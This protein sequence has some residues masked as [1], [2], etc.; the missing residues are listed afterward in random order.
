MHAFQE[1]EF[2]ELQTSPYAQLEKSGKAIQTVEQ[3][4]SWVRTE[5]RQVFPHGALAAGYGRLHAGGVTLD[6]VVAVDYPVGQLDGI[7]NRS[8]CIDTPILR[9]WLE[10]RKPQLF[11][12]HKPWPDTPA[13]WFASFQRHEL[14]NVAAHAFVDAE[15]CMG[16]Y[17]SFHRIPSPLCKQHTIILDAITPILH[18]AFMRVI[19]H[20]ESAD[21]VPLPQSVHLSQREAEVLHWIAQGKTNLDIASL[22]GLSENTIKH[23]VTS[24]LQKSG[25]PNRA[26]LAA[27]IAQQD[28]RARAA[29]TKVL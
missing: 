24:T 20:I 21:R 29:G 8:G 17:F 9:R 10:T 5:V 1:A 3:F 25:A 27:M 12:S 18:A 4:K 2:A 22:L 16:T 19:D 13:A 14:I 23:H 11:E 26:R 28:S 15:R 6:G 7:R